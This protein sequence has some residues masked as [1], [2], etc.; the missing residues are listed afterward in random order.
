M[1][2]LCQTICRIGWLEKPVSTQG[3]LEKS[4]V[5]ALLYTNF[6]NLTNF[7]KFRHQ[8]FGCPKNKFFKQ[9]IYKD[10]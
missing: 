1:R 4:R 10:I 5:P 8:T 3:A 9:I 6:S 2:I 7:E